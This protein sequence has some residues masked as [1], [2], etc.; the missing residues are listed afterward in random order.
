MVPERANTCSSKKSSCLPSLSLF[1]F[2]Y[3]GR[4]FIAEMEKTKPTT[5][6]RKNINLKLAKTNP[7]FYVLNFVRLNLTENAVAIFLTWVKFEQRW[8]LP[9]KSMPSNSLRC[10]YF[11][12]NKTWSWKCSRSQTSSTEHVQSQTTERFPFHGIHYTM[13]AVWFVSC[14]GTTYFSVPANLKTAFKK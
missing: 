9:D 14:N 12:L 4:F 6:H 1:P 8:I 10:I 5:R 2:L 13:N 3:L 11:T 7:A